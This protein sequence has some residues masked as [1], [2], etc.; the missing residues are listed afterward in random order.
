VLAAPAG[1]AVQA[2]REPFVAGTFGAYVAFV[3][4]AAIDWDW[5]LP[6]ITVTGLLCGA[7]L[8]VAARDE[9][10]PLV[11]G[12]GWRGPLLIPVLAAFAFSFVGL[13]GNRADAA[14]S[15]AASH[16]DW[17]TAGAQARRAGGWAPW[18]ADALV[19][20]ADAASA[21]GNTTA[22]RLLLREAVGRDRH[23]FDLWRR[24]AAV[25]TGPERSRALARAAELNPLG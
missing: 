20:Q 15:L 10:S 7:L 22:A 2:R 6:A 17:T 24:L 5:E 14:A 11:L 19:L 8:V 25:T 21:A 3:A 12:S 4:H 13:V 18:S 9:R 23:D 1:A 16:G